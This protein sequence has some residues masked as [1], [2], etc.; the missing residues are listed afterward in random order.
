MPRRR[1]RPSARLRLT[2]S[3]WSTSPRTTGS[4]SGSSAASSPF[5]ASSEEVGR[6]GRAPDHDDGA[7]EDEELLLLLRGAAR[8]CLGPGAC[9]AGRLPQG[10]AAADDDALLGGHGQCPSSSSCVVE[11]VVWGRPR[12]DLGGGGRRRR[13]GRPRRR[14]GRGAA[15][16]STTDGI[17]PR[18]D[19]GSELWTTRSTRRLVASASGEA[20]RVERTG[21]AVAGRRDARPGQAVDLD[22]A[23]EHLGRAVGGQLPVRGVA[24]GRR[25]DVRVPLDRDAVRDRRAAPGPRRRAGAFAAG[26]RTALPWSKKTSLA[27][28]P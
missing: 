14:P 19:S 13:G 18:T 4:C 1:Y 5:G 8:R 28:S 9:P 6:G 11:E 26:C 25:D 15:A 7:D 2:G 22:E 20:A 17:S 27:T 24:A 12:A 3:T 23:P 10:L 21:V 16:P